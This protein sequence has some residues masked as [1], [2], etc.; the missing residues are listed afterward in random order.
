ML[1]N[2]CRDCQ[3]QLFLLASGLE[4][5]V[6]APRLLLCNYFPFTSDS[7]AGK[8]RTVFCALPTIRSW[9]FFVFVSPVVRSFLI[10]LREPVGWRHHRIKEH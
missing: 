8:Y 9:I 6:G 3:F 1:E 10:G 7:R 4:L 2:R 5:L